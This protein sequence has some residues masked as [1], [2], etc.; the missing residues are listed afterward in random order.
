MNCGAVCLQYVHNQHGHKLSLKKARELAK[1][2]RHGTHFPDL[3]DALRELGY[4]NVRA[5]Q[6]LKWSELKRL[7]DAGNDVFLSWLSDLP[8][9]NYPMPADGHWSVARKVTKENLVIFDPDVRQEITLPKEYWLSRWYDFEIDRAGKRTDY[10]KSAI[11]ARYPH[12]LK[13]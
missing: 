5:K 3:M 8:A 1:T 6:N 4:C 7:V 13:I 2:G 9:G 12:K 11:I 10:I